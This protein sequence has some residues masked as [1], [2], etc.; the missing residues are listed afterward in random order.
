MPDLP[1]A[2]PVYRVADKR[3]PLSS[4]AFVA[5]RTPGGVVITAPKPDLADDADELAPAVDVD[6][7]AARTYARQRAMMLSIGS[8]RQPCS[9]SH[10]VSRPGAAVASRGADRCG[11]R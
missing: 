11:S 2:A 9:P 8:G 10:R 6:L 4:R 1:R 3:E 5:A 7:A